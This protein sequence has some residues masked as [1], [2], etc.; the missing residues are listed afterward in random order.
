MPFG[1]FKGQEVADLEHGYLD[2]LKNNVKLYGAL[3]DEVETTLSQSNSDIDDEEIDVIVE[4][5][6][7]QCPITP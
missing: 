5:G 1:K 4:G 2:W 7:P 3:K 6:W